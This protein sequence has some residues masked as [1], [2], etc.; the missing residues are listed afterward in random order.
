MGPVWRVMKGR[1]DTCDRCGRE[2]ED[3]PAVGRVVDFQFEPDEKYCWDC[4]AYITPFVDDVDPTS[5]FQ[6]VTKPAIP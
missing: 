3:Y 4:Y 5:P 6:P 2:I 1:K